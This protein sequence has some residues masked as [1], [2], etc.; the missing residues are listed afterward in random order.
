[1][2]YFSTFNKK[3]GIDEDGRVFLQLYSAYYTHLRIL[4]RDVA[5]SRV[6][7]TSY[8]LWEGQLRVG[9][10]G[11]GMKWYLEQG[12]PGPVLLARHITC[13]ACPKQATWLWFFWYQHCTS[14][15]HAECCSKQYLGSYSSG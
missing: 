9:Q 14:S 15:P 7:T 11:A 3:L 13:Y 6:D 5:F 12:S 4:M 10:P 1:M 2:G 8:Q